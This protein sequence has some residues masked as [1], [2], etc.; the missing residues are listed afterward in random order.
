MIILMMRQVKNLGQL[1]QCHR[2]DRNEGQNEERPGPTPEAC[3]LAV[4]PSGGPQLTGL[5]V[6]RRSEHAHER[7]GWVP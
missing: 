2:G 3:K 7:L 1:D 6:L 4:A 5:C